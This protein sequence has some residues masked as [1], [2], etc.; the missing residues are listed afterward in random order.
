MKAEKTD[1]IEF[2][3]EVVEVL[4][5]T[6][7]KVKLKDKDHFVLATLSGRMR[8]NNINVLQH[9]KV[10]VEVSIYD[11]TKGRIIYRRKN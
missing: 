3:G 2:E 7:F 6:M 8:T 10:T 11:L 9:D 1:K 5:G 4:R